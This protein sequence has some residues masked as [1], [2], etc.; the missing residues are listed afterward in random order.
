MSQQW[1]R[2][3]LG[4][5]AYLQS[6]LDFRAAPEEG[7]EVPDAGHIRGEGADA[8]VGLLGPVNHVQ[9][10]G[11]AEAR[12]E[13]V[14]GSEGQVAH[15]G[16]GVALEGLGRQ[17]LIDEGG[18]LPVNIGSSRQ[19]SVRLLRTTD[20]GSRAGSSPRGRQSKVVSPD[21]LT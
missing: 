5:G 17:P 9:D 1:R 2:R 4:Y 15:A 13:P 8:N 7:I 21:V 12:V 14:A 18:A 20:G 10:G 6:V 16:S 19:N 3:R 11:H